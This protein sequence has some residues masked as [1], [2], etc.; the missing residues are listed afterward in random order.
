[1]RKLC[2]LLFISI[3][4]Y[5]VTNGQFT[6]IG[7]GLGYSSAYQFHDMPWSANRSGHLNIF[8]NGI[9]KSNLPILI[10]PSFTYLLPHITFQAINE[11]IPSMNDIFIRTVTDQYNSPFNSPDKS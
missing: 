7:G 2:I 3:M 5:S 8:L 9:Y 1:M 6:K 4:T 11:I 10:S